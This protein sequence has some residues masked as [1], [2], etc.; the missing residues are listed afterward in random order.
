MI[1]GLTLMIAGY[2]SETALPTGAMWTDDQAAA[3]QKASAELHGASYGKGHDHSKEHSHNEPDRSSP[4]YLQAKEAF[5]KS[6]TALDRAYSRKMWIKYGIILM[7]VVISGY[8]IVCVG[9]EKMRAD[10]GATQTHKRKR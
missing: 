3:F 7:G 5:E 6:R 1:V 10:E 8:G 4:E 2:W 9:L